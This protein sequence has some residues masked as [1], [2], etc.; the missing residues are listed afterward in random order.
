MMMSTLRALAIGV[1]DYSL[2]G[3]ENLPFCQN[4]VYA[5][6]KAFEVGLKVDPSNIMSCGTTGIVKVSDFINALIQLSKDA[7]PDDILLIYFSGH[8]A[9]NKDTHYLVFSDK[10]ISTKE[11]IKQIESIKAKSKIIFLDC[12]KSGNFEIDGRPTFN[13]D[14]TADEFAGNGYAVF[15]S[16]NSEQSSF[17]HPDKNIS[18][19]TNCLCDALT[20]SSIIRDGKKSLNDIHKLLFLLLSI[21][22]KNNPTSVQTPIYRANLGGTV[23]FEVESYLPYKNQAYFEETDKYIIYAVEPSHNGI[24]KRYSVKAI[25]KQPF[26]FEEIVEINHEIVRK[27]KQLNIFST[28]R[29]E[30]QWYNKSANIVFC[31]YGLDE[32]DIINS[33]FICKTTWVDETQDKA[34]WYQTDKNGEII[35]DTYLSVFAYYESIKTVIDNHS[36]TDGDLITKTN[37]IIHPMIELAEQVIS[38]FNEYTNK[39]ISEQVLIE[40]LRTTIPIIDAL[41]RTETNLGIPSKELENWC[42]CCSNLAATIHDFTL[43]YGNNAFERRTEE[44]RKACMEIT[45]K[46]YYDNM[47]MLKLAERSRV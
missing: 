23:F 38:L 42:Q 35:G 30:R 24:A 6:S 34:W 36:S 8:G 1:S 11:I 43:Y 9:S 13:T 22:N 28:L 32:S 45:I 18:L 10:V 31:Y 7:N 12:C 29:Q 41:Y 25:L 16:S 46:R 4:D 27:V 2:I 15:A 3:A 20:I 17:C 19:F 40:D 39:E 5:I 37:A 47:E 26:L 44:N 33:N 21:W 14:E